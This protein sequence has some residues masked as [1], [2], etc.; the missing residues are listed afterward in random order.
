[1]GAWHRERD[2]ACLP[3][4][5]FTAQMASLEPPPP[6]MLQ[7]LG[8][9]AGDQD[10]MDQFVSVNTGT[11]SPEAFFSPENIGA[12]MQRVGAPAGV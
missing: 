5:E 9:V 3:I 11:L 6:E 1:M 12:I 8:A 4:Y 10:A 7:L 2:A